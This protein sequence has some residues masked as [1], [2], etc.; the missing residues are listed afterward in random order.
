MLARVTSGK[1]GII[2]YLK[3]GMKS[4]RELSRDELDH[5]ICIDGNI[6][7][8]DDLIKQLNDE[9][10]KENYLHVTLSF[11]ERDL[12]ES[13]IKEAYNDYKKSLMTAYDTDEYNIYA[14][15]HYPKTK[16][17]VDKKTGETIE[18]FPH[19]HIVLPKK[20]LVTDKSLNPFGKYKDNIPFHDSIQ[21]SVNKKH[22]LESPYDNQRKYRIISDN[23]DFISRYKGDTFKGNRGEFKS[24]LFDLINDKNI[25]SMIEFEKELSKFGEVSKGKA[26]AVDEYFK[27]KLPGES[28]NIRLT[29]TCFK[30]AYIEDR[31]LL[32]A[33]PTDKQ[34][35]KL[36]NEWIDTRSHEMKH[37]HPASPKLRKEYY[38]LNKAQREEFLNGRKAEYN[39][40]NNIGQSQRQKTSIKP[41]TERNR[42]RQFAEI[43]NGLPGLPQRGLVRTEPGRTDVPESVLSGNEHN[44]LDTRRPGG[45]NKLRRA[46][47]RDRG[48]GRNNSLLRTGLPDQLVKPMA[49]RKAEP[50]SKANTVAES[51][52]QQYQATKTSKEEL[53]HFRVIRKTLDPDLLLSHFEQSHGLVRSNYTTF[54]AKDGSP[55][56][57]VGSRAYNVSDFCTQHMHQS[58]NDTKS[59]LRQTYQHQHQAKDERHAINSISFVSRYVTQSYT[60]EAKLARINETMMIFKHLKMKERIGDRKMA[61]SDLETKFRVKPEQADDVNSIDNSDIELRSIADNY[62]RQQELAKSLTSRMD[63]LVATKDLKGKHVDFSDKTTGEKVFKDHGHRIIMN[64][65]KPNDNQVAQAM[66]LA[67]EKFGT[68]KINGSKEFKQQVI[69][70]AVA[71][72]LNIVFKSKSMQAEFVKCKR[73]AEEN[74]LLNKA[75][76]KHDAP[77]NDKEQSATTSPSDLTQTAKV[78]KQALSDAERIKSDLSNSTL[79]KNVDFDKIA[80]KHMDLLTSHSGTVGYKYVDEAIQSGTE[81]SEEYKQSIA[82]AVTAAPKIKPNQEQ[83]DNVLVTLVDH[84]TAPYLHKADAKDSY[85]VEL[86]NG[87]TKWGIGLK[88]AVEKSGAK[89]GDVVDVDRVGQRDV[90]VMGDIRNEKGEK[91]GFEPIETK[92]VEWSIE[93]KGSVLD[94]EPSTNEHTTVAKALTANTVK[95]DLKMMEIGETQDYQGLAN[96]HQGALLSNAGTEAYTEIKN[97]ILDNCKANPEYDRFIDKS[98]KEVDGQTVQVEESKTVSQDKPT[99]DT[100]VEIFE[101]KYQWNDKD[102]NL[103]VTVNEQHPSKVEPS[104]LDKIVKADSFLKNYSLEQV[105][106]GQL[107]Q[108][109]AKGI[110]PVSKVF[111]TD[112]VS[113]MA[114]K[115]T[116]GL[117]LK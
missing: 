57:K 106:S 77:V 98:L 22:N 32:R 117:T 94:D 105:Q 48:R 24:N 40:S 78:I 43:R 89:V 61:L 2:D 38:S 116:Q 76:K 108:K 67:A 83:S 90:T 46:I 16:S 68:V 73:E 64:S 81:H 36:L 79:D 86:S 115:I 96:K 4:G 9:D 30:S 3:N 39:A 45:H 11:G 51:Y 62:K 97:A 19:V 88:E 99:K 85:F 107:D 111:D 52:L 56:I 103:L 109:L 58:W 54:K 17:Y 41:G 93:V 26:G 49:A 5:R 69:D 91:I 75:S 8:T 59:L 1:D 74:Q 50:I 66:T 25:K 42:V 7:I 15:I 33:K 53:Q 101:V 44:D 21:E 23:A 28:K 55:R 112:G 12:P 6:S 114:D 71:K 35:D 84:G 29:D 65:R 47:N 72:D 82:K 37:I 14:E 92:R 27:I 104:T 34:I 10:K 31:E 113:K 18:R 110:Q 20:N 63:E 100:N 70:V 13:K 60:S 102:S 95:S 87:E 80:S